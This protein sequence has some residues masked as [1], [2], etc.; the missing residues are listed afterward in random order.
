VRVEAAMVADRAEGRVAA[1]TEA[2]M[3]AM[4]AGEKAA[5]AMA[6]VEMEDGEKVV[7]EMEE[8]VM[9]GV[10]EGA[11]AVEVTA[12][13]ERAA[14]GVAVPAEGSVEVERAAAV[15]AEEGVPSKSR[16]CLRRR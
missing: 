4:T 8:G 1:A 9:E 10:M 14:V 3:A 15:T 6:L 7:E 5:G 13:E 11:M 2:G 12:E 16:L